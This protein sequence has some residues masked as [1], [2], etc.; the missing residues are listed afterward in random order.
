MLK[1]INWKLLLD[2]KIK[3]GSG[4]QLR[5]GDSLRLLSTLHYSPRLKNCLETQTPKAHTDLPS[6]LS[7]RIADIFH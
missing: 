5:F 1:K 2:H 6:I 3:G 4:W 7:H